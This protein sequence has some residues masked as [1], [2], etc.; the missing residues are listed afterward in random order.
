MKKEELMLGD[1][2]SVSGTN[3]QV[4]A[5]GRTK[6]GFLDEKGEMFYHDYD[7]IHP[8]PLTAEILEKNGFLLHKS[9]SYFKQYMWTTGGISDYADVYIE[10]GKDHQDNWRWDL[11]Q[12]KLNFYSGEA[13][14]LKKHYVHE[15]QNALRLSGIEKEIE[16]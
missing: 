9:A 7:N 2:V 15:L 6:A 13:W 1:W 14:F 4:A 10:V 12:F 3:M 16:P 8:I 11:L 5:L